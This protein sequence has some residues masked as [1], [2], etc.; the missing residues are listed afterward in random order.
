MQ[1]DDTTFLSRFATRDLGPEHFDHRGHL[2][3]AWLLLTH[4]EPEEATRRCLE[5]I[6]DLAAKFDAPEKFGHTLTKAL[7]R[8]IATRLDAESRG[9]FERFLADNT[10]L[11]DN[12][13]GVLARHYSATRLNAPEARTGWVEPDLAP[14]PQSVSPNMNTEHSDKIAAQWRATPNPLRRGGISYGRIF[15]T[16][17]LK[18]FPLLC[19]TTEYDWLPGWRCQ[20]LHSDSG[21]TEYNVVFKTDFFGTEELWVCTRFEP[22]RA[23]PW[24]MRAPPRTTAPRWTS[25]WSKTATA[26]PPAPGRSPSRRST[27]GATRRSPPLRPRPEATWRRSSPPSPTMWS[28]V[29]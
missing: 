7:M 19:P 17:P 11:V 15:N 26:P 5:G 28:G 13:E 2:R 16:T 10:D 9:D 24:S 20:L 6:R 25:A 4:F 22:G 3:M 18:L 12:A 21:Y 14:L 8:I 1:L 27:N 23:G 29:R